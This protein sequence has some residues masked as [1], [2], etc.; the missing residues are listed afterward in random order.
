M[1]KQHGELSDGASAENARTGNSR[2]FS[3][4][5]GEPVAALSDSEHEAQTS[6]LAAQ[7]GALLCDY[8]RVVLPDEPDVR[9]ELED[10]LGKSKARAGGWHG[11]YDRSASVAEGG[12]IAWC[13]NDERAKIEGLLC[14][15]PG[16]ACGALGAR[17]LSFLRWAHRRGK[18]TRIDFAVDD[19]HGR[20]TRERILAALDGGTLLM[21]WQDYSQVVKGKSGELRGWTLYLGKR[22]GQ[23]QMRFYD[24]GLEQGLPGMQWLRC[25]LE[26]KGAFAHRLASE[27]FTK[28]ADAVKAQIVKRIKFVVPMATDTNKA[29]WPLAPWWA[30]FIGEIEPGESLVPGVKPVCTVERLARFVERCAGPSIATVVAALDGDEDW[31]DGLIER[32]VWRMNPQQIKLLERLRDERAAGAPVRVLCAPGIW[33]DATTGEVMGATA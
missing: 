22:A 16:R 11:W 9:A 12:L 29:R 1:D 30:E 4:Q 7:R 26:A 15:L 33:V 14:D 2:G 25:E 10:W 19:M 6:A 13:S 24:K 8:I 3:I 27:Y 28:G 17:L 20:L 5:H 21:R 32:S 18:I 31:L 23:S